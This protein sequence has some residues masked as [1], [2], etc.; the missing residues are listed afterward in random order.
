MNMA[1]ETPYLKISYSMMTIGPPEM[2]GEYLSGD[3][4]EWICRLDGYSDK[5][6][7]FS[8]ED[9]EDEKDIIFMLP[10]PTAIS[11]MNGLKAIIE[12]I[13]TTCEKEKE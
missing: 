7:Y 2:N 13:N 5:E 6:I 8:I 10:V 1:K 12:A 9:Q 11:L 3:D 4:S